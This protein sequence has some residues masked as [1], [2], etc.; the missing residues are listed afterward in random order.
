M[1]M[2]VYFDKEEGNR[3]EREKKTMLVKLDKNNEKRGG[4]EGRIR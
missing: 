2:D 3:K 4:K 1:R